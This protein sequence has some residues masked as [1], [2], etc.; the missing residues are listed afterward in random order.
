MNFQQDVLP[1]N[2]V[3]ILKYLITQFTNSFG[4]MGLSHIKYQRNLDSNKL[5]RKLGIGFV[6]L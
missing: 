6:Y 2:A 4:K 3:A 5:K 1:E